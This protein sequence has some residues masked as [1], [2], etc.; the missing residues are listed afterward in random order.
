MSENA[1]SALCDYMLEWTVTQY[2][3][4]DGAMSPEVFDRAVSVI[5]IAV[6]LLL[7][8]F[9]LVLVYVLIWRVFGG[10]KRG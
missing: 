3:K 4:A 8:A 6:P 1:L 10:G 9:C 5:G 7:L 2:E